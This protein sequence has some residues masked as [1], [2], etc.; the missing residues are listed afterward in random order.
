MPAPVRRAAQA[1]LERAQAARPTETVAL[2][3]VLLRC[4]AQLDAQQ[5]EVAA[6]FAS[7]RESARALDE[8]VAALEREVHAKQDALEHKVDASCAALEEKAVA[9]S[10]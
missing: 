10:E 6:W 7:R 4:T 8:R 2:A 3:V 5:R 9:V 1:A